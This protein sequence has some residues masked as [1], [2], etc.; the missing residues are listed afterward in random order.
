MDDEKL[1]ELIKSV[2]DEGIRRFLECHGGKIKGV[3]AAKLKEPDAADALNETLRR[4]W[5][6]IGT[7]DPMIARLHVWAA[8]IAR[9]VAVGILAD[10]AKH[11]AFIKQ[12]GGGI[13]DLED[14]SSDHR[15]QLEV[16]SAALRSIPWEQRYVL[17]ADLA[18][19]GSAPATPLAIR[20]HV[21]VGYIY[22]LRKRGRSGVRQY[23]ID[24]GETYETA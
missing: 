10:I 2:P 15:P 18:A 5:I 3:I 12:I 21:N 6:S 16:P 11:R 4:V 13:E 7:Y 9:N 23:L 8:A 22:V 24:H 17:E 19:K 1:V 20:L 14:R